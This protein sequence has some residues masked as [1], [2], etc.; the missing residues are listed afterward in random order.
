MFDKMIESQ[1]E[2]AEFK[3]RRGYFLVSSVVVGILFMTAVVISIFAADFG[4]GSSSFELA[5]MIAPV[6]MAA[7]EPE[8]P[9]PRSLT[10]CF[11]PTRPRRF[12]SISWVVPTA[13]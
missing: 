9:K 4:L 12:A 6:D 10:A 5:E 7:A 1:T 2:G 11:I 3:N 8:P 13:W